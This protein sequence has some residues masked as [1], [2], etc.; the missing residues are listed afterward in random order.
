MSAF[1]SFFPHHVELYISVE[2]SFISVRKSY[3]LLSSSLC[4]SKVFPGH[5][6]LPILYFQGRIQEELVRPRL[7]S[8]S[9][10]DASVTAFAPVQTY[11]MPEGRAGCP[12]GGHGTEGVK[13]EG[14]AVV[15]ITVIIIIIV[16]RGGS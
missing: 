10:W 7:S 15:V 14:V 6:K 12:Q 1:S 11:S 5:S 3:Y 16:V 9:S 4:F 8:W 2:K 13:E